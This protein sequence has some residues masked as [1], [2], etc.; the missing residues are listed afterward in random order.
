MNSIGQKQ[1]GTQTAL[2]VLNGKVRCLSDFLRL[3]SIKTTDQTEKADLDRESE[4]IACEYE[5]LAKELVGY[6]A[7]E[8]PKSALTYY[9]NW[10]G[11]KSIDP[12]NAFHVINHIHDPNSDLT[13]VAM[14]FL[15]LR[16][17]TG[18]NFRVFDV[19]AVEDWATKAAAKKNL[20]RCFARQD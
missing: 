2:D 1:D 4:N 12:Q 11:E 15:A 9:L 16:E 8:N 7:Y 3:R 13:D 19:D 6:D 17:A 20:S 14:C 10:H 5:R 18:I